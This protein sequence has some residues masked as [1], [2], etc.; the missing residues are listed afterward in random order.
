MDI[1]T[2]TIYSGHVS[3]PVREIGV[4]LVLTLW[5]TLWSLN[6]IADM[7][8]KLPNQL[9]LTGSYP[10]NP[11]I[12]ISRVGQTDHRVFLSVLY[13]LLNLVGLPQC[14]TSLSF[15]SLS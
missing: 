4:L 11:P 12:G 3:V 13:M 1:S 10:G 9:I 6:Q 15:I 5:S 8:I 14:S 2:G 7:D